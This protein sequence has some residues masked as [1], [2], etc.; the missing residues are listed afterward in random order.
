MI[1]RDATQHVWTVWYFANISSEKGILGRFW[2]PGEKRLKK[3]FTEIGKKRYLLPPQKGLKVFPG[4][5]A[6]QKRSMMEIKM[7]IFLSR[8]TLKFDGLPWKASGHLLYATSSFV[9]HFVA[10]CEF[11]LELRSGNS[12]IRAKI[13]LTSVTLTLDLDLLHGHHFCQW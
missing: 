13:V 5:P 6:V 3:A 1:R 7:A 2:R 8:V 4:R 9:H 12:Y 11:K 10:I